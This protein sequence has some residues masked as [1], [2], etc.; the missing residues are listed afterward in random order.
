MDTFDTSFL[1]I[2]NEHIMNTILLTTLVV[3]VPKYHT[4][5]IL[6]RC[7]PTGLPPLRGCPRRCCSVVVWLGR[8]VLDHSVSIVVHSWGWLHRSSKHILGIILVHH[9][10]LMMILRHHH[11]IL[12]IL[13]NIR[14]KITFTKTRRFLREYDRKF[15]WKKIESKS[16]L[17]TVQISVFYHLDKMK[18]FIFKVNRELKLGLSY[19]NSILCHFCPSII[20]YLREL[21]YS[22]K[23]K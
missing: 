22:R 5:L 12:L 13:W 11:H 7:P 17:S 8:F 18:N 20:P 10:L 23:I 14:L 1:N 6:I 15:V 2:R 21:T 4:E 9:V 3:V 16:K 19:V